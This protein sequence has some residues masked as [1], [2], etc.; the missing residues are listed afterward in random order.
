MST[1][2]RL[3]QST[4]PPLRYAALD[5]RYGRFERHHSA[6]AAATQ[7][8]D[9]TNEPRDF[10]P[11]PCACTEDDLTLQVK[12]LAHEL[13]DTPSADWK[14]CPRD[15][16][17]YNHAEDDAALTELQ[18]RF[19][20]PCTMAGRHAMYPAIRANHVKSVH[21]L[22]SIRCGV[23]WAMTNEASRC[24]HL[25]ILRLLIEGGNTCPQSALSAAVEA[26][27]TDCVDYLLSRGMTL[28][29]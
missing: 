9:W 15:R 8:A 2:I 13:R 23:T 5:T 26:G 10:V 7:C 22:L 19:S 6:R 16:S 29:Q 12:C 1:H 17:K 11:A 28:H 18:S 14:E 4:S 21:Y 20:N 27:K 25:G 3:L 24:G